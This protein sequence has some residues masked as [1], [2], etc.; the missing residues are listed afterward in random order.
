M[1]VFLERIRQCRIPN[2]APTTGPWSA[3]SRVTRMADTHCWNWSREEKAWIARE[4]CDEKVTVVQVAVRNDG[5]AERPQ[6]FE[7]HG[8]A[9]LAALAVSGDE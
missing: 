6:G 1:I 8:Q 5:D 3:K 4:S 2:E 7:L 9:L